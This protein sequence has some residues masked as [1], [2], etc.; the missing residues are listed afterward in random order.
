MSSSRGGTHPSWSDAC[1]QG[2]GRSTRLASVMITAATDSWAGRLREAASVLR[3]TVDDP[4]LRLDA[5]VVERRRR[6][7][8]GMI[9][10]GVA[11]APNTSPTEAWSATRRWPIN[12]GGAR[13]SRARR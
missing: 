7:R 6:P 4:Q 8:L 1:R 3:Q 5:S 12:R 10:A 9:D 11:W 13:L 2:S